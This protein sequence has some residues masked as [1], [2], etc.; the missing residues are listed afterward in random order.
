MPRIL[1]LLAVLG[2]FVILSPYPATV[3]TSGCVA[4]L[5]LPVYRWLRA[6]QGKIISVS[7]YI[8][9]LCLCIIT[10]IAVATVLI[11]PQVINGVRR[12]NAWRS[13]GWEL[14]PRLV[15]YR[16]MV[17]VW[18]NKMPGLRQ[19]I[20]DL[21]DNLG[22]IINSSAKTLLSGGLGL[23]GG[24][25]T[26]FWLLFLLVVLAAM[27][28]VYA[29]TLYR[30]TLRITCLP[31]DSLDRFILAL[32]HALKAVVVGVLLVAMIQGTLTGI[33]LRLAGVA[34]PAFWGL[35]AAFSAVIPLVGTTLVWVPISILLMLQGRLGA[36]I[37]LLVWGTVVVSGADNFF[38]PYFLK[39][40]IE[41]SMFVLLLS[42][43]CSVAFFG[44]VGLIAGPVLVA[45]C[46]QALKESDILAG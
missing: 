14:S 9:G 34:D 35:L 46:G 2:W 27:G 6:R 44:P 45:L 40:G 16:E 36:G 18:I 10:P 21:G 28:V 7:L 1:A 39:T 23:A 12:L 30:L 25:M 37:F 5:T 22:T 19:W 33:G 13:S 17:E 24:T 11:T 8:G 43:L 42:I 41:A 3:F 4:C 31:K 26:A 32:R 20:S 38:R 15:E 29:P